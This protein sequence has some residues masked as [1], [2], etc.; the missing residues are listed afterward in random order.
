MNQSSQVSKRPD[1]NG[2]R[3]MHITETMQGELGTSYWVPRPRQAIKR[4]FKDCRFCHRYRGHP[5][6]TLVGAL[7]HERLAPFQKPF[8]CVGIDYFGPLL[9]TVGRSPVKGW[10]LL[11]NCL[12]RA[13]HLEISWSLWSFTLVVSQERSSMTMELVLL[14][15]KKSYGED[16]SHGIYN[17]FTLI[18]LIKES[19]ESFLHPQVLTL[20]AFGNAS[21][22]LTSY[23]FLRNKHFPSTVVCFPCEMSLTLM[24]P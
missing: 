2:F 15:E 23:S 24:V 5:Q 7:P 13:I 11:I 9:V 20:E 21:F 22:P 16:L 10:G 18:K 12:T 8:M 4:V 1:V 3:M 17:V 14:L 6:S 19:S